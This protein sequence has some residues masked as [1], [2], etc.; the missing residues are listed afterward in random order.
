MI[1]QFYE[2]KSNR[3]VK[4]FYFEGLPDVCYYSLLLSHLNVTDL[5][6]LDL[7]FICAQSCPTT[8]ETAAWSLPRRQ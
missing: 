6:Y 2:V 8:P 7:V 1:K 3:K 4:M 5:V